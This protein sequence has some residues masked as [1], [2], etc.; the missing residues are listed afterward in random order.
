M[1]R[2]KYDVNDNFFDEPNI[3]NSYWAGFLAADGCITPGG[4]NSVRLQLARKDREHLFKF[5]GI[6][7]YTGTIQ[8]SWREDSYSNEASLLQV[9]SARW[10]EKL[11]TV[12]NVTPRKTFTLEPPSNLELSCQLAYVVG[13]IDGD[14]SVFVKN[15]KRGYRFLTLSVFGTQMICNWIAEIFNGLT[16]DTNYRISKPNRDGKCFRYMIIGKRAEQIASRLLAITELDDVRLNRKWNV[17]K[18]WLNREIKH[19]CTAEST[20]LR[21]CEPEHSEG[22]LACAV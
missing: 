13:L 19:N 3:L 9:T 14:G 7:S 17:A 22:F 11:K 20:L 6:V 21:D 4:C 1:S 10:K 2:K 8:D 12:F 5:K 15:D 18:E 16:S